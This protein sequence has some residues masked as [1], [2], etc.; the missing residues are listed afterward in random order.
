MRVPLS[1]LRDYVDPGLPAQ[2][3]ADVLTMGGLEVE[4]VLRPTAGTRGVRVVEVA[5]TERIAGSDHLTLVRA[6]DGRRTYEIVCGAHNFTVGDRVPAA[7][8]GATLPSGVRIDRRTVFGHTSH[9]MLA[10]PREL[11]VGDDHRGIW[12]LERDAPLGSELADWLDL[13][14]PVLDIAV[15]PDR[16]YALSVVGV[17]RDV[18]ALTGA[19]LRVPGED[20]AGGVGG[21]VGVPV[22]IADADRCRRFDARRIEGLRV[23]PSPAWLQRRL[24][25]VG[26][27]PISNVVD[28]TNHALLETGHPAHAYDLAV[29][30][31]PRI[32]VRDATPGE[33]LV[34]L[35]GAERVLDGDDLVI[36]DADGPVGLAGVMGGARTEVGADTT[37]V[38]LE[39]AS[40]DPAVVLRT[41]RRH[42]LS[43]EASTRFEKTVPEGSVPLGAGR[44]A[45]LVAELGGGLVTAAADHY[46]RPRPREVIRLRT[47]RARGLL[48]MDLGDARQ[49]EL[50][51]AI[52]CAVAAADGVLR[53][54]PPVY[55]PDLRIEADLAEELARVHGYETIPE[56]VPA[57]GQVGG[58]TPEHEARLAVRRAL[59]GG[60]WTEILP[61]PFIADDDVEALGL[62]DDDP[63]R[64]TI[65][66]VNPLS[67]NEAVLRPTLV[68]GLLRTLRY[69]VNRG[70][71]DVAVFEVGHVFLHPSPD[72]PGSDGG[73]GGVVLPAEPTVLGLAACGAFE[74]A[75]HDRGARAADVFDLLGAADLARRTAGRPP[76]RAR[77]TGEAPY[78]PGRA[79]RLELEGRDVG[80][81][82]EL[83]PRVAEA[84]GVPART[85]AG[86]LRLDLLTEGGARPAVGRAPSSLPGLRLDVAVVVDEGVPG[87]AVEQAVRAGAG[88]RLTS[89]RLFDVYRGA[90]LEAG[91]KS[92]AYALRLDDPD[93]QLTDADAEAVI[94]AVERAVG[95]QVDGRLRR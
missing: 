83:H 21:D 66:L 57:T 48:G 33:T 18:A 52:G 84:F 41:A 61:F 64:R 3:L 50:L 7:L 27:R 68:P 72:L 34:T 71:G 9:G 23:G 37:T 10:S 19:D 60:G 55:R 51:S 40:F 79:A 17:A 25:A 28:A 86:E 90:P 74:P 12:V 4:A 69:N 54:T 15:T 42:R 44:C 11:G 38:L 47:D 31:G 81:V 20:P 59:A 93:R 75:V 2:E 56:R 35:D 53:V 6:T 70:T 39:V 8:P 32:D 16:G 36:A 85:L 95:E 58:R 78:H 89:C 22:T 26:V 73:P 77:P 91:R 29:L 30:A 5:S 82:G 65:A 45:A 46:P 43:T 14:D 62:A 67:R 92:L 88:D 94:T 49:G 13:D 87:A 76:L 1:W 63:R 24:A 80:V